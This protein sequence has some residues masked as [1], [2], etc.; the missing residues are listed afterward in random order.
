MTEIFFYIQILYFGLNEDPTEYDEIDE[1]DSLPI[2]SDIVID[3]NGHV[4]VM[5]SQV[6]S[7]CQVLR[8]K[9]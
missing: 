8:F 2:M 7:K 6:V 9:S 5:T 1:F 4:I 3:G